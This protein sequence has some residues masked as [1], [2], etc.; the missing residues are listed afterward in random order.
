MD[1]KYVIYIQALPDDDLENRIS[2]K[3]YVDWL[4]KNDIQHYRWK[5]KQDGR[6]EFL[7]DYEMLTFR[8]ESEEDKVHFAMR[9]A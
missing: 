8:F 9:W 3:P 2:A 5:W 7:D 1:C 4:R 6:N